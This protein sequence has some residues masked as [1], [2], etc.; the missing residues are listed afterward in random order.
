MSRF[1]ITVD[2]R[3]THAFDSILAT[4]ITA[5][6]MA[7]VQ[8][9]FSFDAFDFPLSEQQCTSP[10]SSKME[11]EN[12]QTSQTC[13]RTFAHFR[14]MLKNIESLRV[15]LRNHSE[16]QLWQYLTRTGSY[17]PNDENR[18]L[19]LSANACDHGFGAVLCRRLSYCLIKLAN[20]RGC[21]QISATHGETCGG[22]ASLSRIRAQ[23][24]RKMPQGYR[25]KMD[26]PDPVT[27]FDDYGMRS[28]VA[29]EVRLLL[30]PGIYGGG[31]V[32]NVTG[33]AR[34]AETKQH[35]RQHPDGQYD[36]A[37]EPDDRKRLLSASD[38]RDS[39]PVGATN[40]LILE[41]GS[42]PHGVDWK[43]L[44]AFID[45]NMSVTVMKNGEN[46][47]QSLKTLMRR[48]LTIYVLRKSDVWLM[49]KL[50]NENSTYCQPIENHPS[51]FSGRDCHQ[52]NILKPLGEEQLWQCLTRSGSYIPNGENR[53]LV[54]S[55]NACDHGFG[56]VLCRRLSYC[57]IKLANTRGCV[58]ISA[59]HGEV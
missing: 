34:T 6:Q 59:T 24:S 33:K 53:P 8:H 10:V 28:L 41:I 12:L 40:E 58:Q 5:E 47:S 14:Y 43:K 25:V 4:R 56:A 44:L 49:Q 16:E 32:A 22:A 52:A 37:D 1:H 54:L 18:P 55:A 45:T 38:Y 36:C 29:I 42:L 48:K 21:V 39:R 50:S 15:I 3:Y 20:T 30:V 46:Q 23:K 19:V 27:M 11:D 35:G 7:S 57:L 13:C 9:H 31:L 51:E 2:Q 26:M 17:I